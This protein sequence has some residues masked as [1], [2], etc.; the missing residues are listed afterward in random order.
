MI[1]AKKFETRSWSAKYRGPLLIHASLKPPKDH[2]VIG[3]NTDPFFNQF[4]PDITDLPYGA[5]SVRLNSR[6]LKTED[7]NNAQVP[8]KNVLLTSHMRT[9]G[10]LSEGRYALSVRRLSDHRELPQL[11]KQN[12]LPHTVPYYLTVNL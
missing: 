10:D 8:F 7:L 12:H 3:F 6:Y 2:Q 11:N 9:F 5:L 4:I 1:G